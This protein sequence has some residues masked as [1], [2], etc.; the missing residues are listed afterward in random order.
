MPGCSRPNIYKVTGPEQNTGHSCCPQKVQSLE[1]SEAQMTRR[2]RENLGNTSTQTQ[3]SKSLLKGFQLQTSLTS[4]VLFQTPL[5][6]VI[7]LFV[8]TNG[9]SNFSNRTGSGCRKLKKKLNHRV[10][11]NICTILVLTWKTL[12]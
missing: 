10:M 11:V 12:T 4:H 2:V 3:A 8:H 9:S 7:I 6:L 1:G 5:R